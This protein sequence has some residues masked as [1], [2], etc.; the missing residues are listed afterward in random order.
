MGHDVVPSFLTIQ[1]IM[2]VSEM[3][4][5]SHKQ[6]GQYWANIAALKDKIG[7]ACQQGTAG[8]T[9]ALYLVV[10]WYHQS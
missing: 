2:P 6:L 7:P 5:K 3:L 8:L 4:Q 1:S 10:R 9:R